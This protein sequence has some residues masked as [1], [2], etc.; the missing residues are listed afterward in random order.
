M[1]NFDFY[2]SNMTVRLKRSNGYL[3][4]KELVYSLYVFLAR[5]GSLSYA[6]AAADSNKNFA[7]RC[8]SDYSDA[9]SLFYLISENEIDVCSL[10]EVA[11]DY[12]HERKNT[13]YSN[14]GS[15]YGNIMC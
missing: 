3:N 10:D 8:T 11:D 12:F 1:N 15:E 13:I 9:L 4:D 2:D 6:V 7:I 5:D 14:H